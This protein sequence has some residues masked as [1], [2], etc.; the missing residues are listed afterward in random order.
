MYAARTLASGGACEQ[1]STLF[2]SAAMFYT[3]YHSTLHYE[4][5]RL[6]KRDRSN[7]FAEVERPRR[8]ENLGHK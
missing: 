8:F 1:D 5:V 2:C 6:S 7:P 4:D 3:M